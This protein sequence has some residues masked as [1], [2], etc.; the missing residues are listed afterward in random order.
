MSRSLLAQQL[1]LLTMMT[2][3]DTALAQSSAFSRLAEAGNPA[4]GN[5][6]M[7]FKL[8]IAAFYVDR[9]DQTDAPFCLIVY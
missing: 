8:G 6:D 3:T 2:C 7:Q 4:N 5:C 9:V 1:K